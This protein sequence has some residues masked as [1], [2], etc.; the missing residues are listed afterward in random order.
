MALAQVRIDELLDEYVLC[1][2]LGHSWDELPDPEFSTSLY[3][4]STGALALRCT[5]CRAERYDYIANDMTVASR[6]YRYPPQYNTIPGQGS[7]PNLRGEMFRRS[8]L[9]HR[10]RQRRNGK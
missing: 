7:R 4:S 5:R 2:T 10:Y 3:R 8:L 9:V 6:Q 1:R